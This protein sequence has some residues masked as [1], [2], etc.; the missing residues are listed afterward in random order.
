M[1]ES[2]DTASPRSS[3]SLTLGLCA[4]C[5]GAVDVRTR[6]LAIAGSTVRVYCSQRCVA[7]PEPQVAAAAVEP[8]PPSRWRHV[9]RVALGV[10]M[11]CF[12]SGYAPSRGATVA[13]P[14]APAAQPAATAE[15][16]Q[17]GP[18]WPPSEKDWLAAIAS[19]AWIHPLDGP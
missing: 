6:H 10:P 8:P 12:P 7:E 13:T 16:A 17:L 11:L 5:G 15:P 14:A 4:R 18:A 2:I 3:S 1:A 9:A 19:D